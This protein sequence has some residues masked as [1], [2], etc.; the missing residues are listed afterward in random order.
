MIF[1]HK[2]INAQLIDTVSNYRLR[3]Q[4]ALERQTLRI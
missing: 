2:S 3:F 4:Y 1:S